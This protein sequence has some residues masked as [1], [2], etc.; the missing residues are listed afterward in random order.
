MAD[1]RMKSQE[2]H[3]N[4]SEPPVDVQPKALQPPTD[5]EAKAA[6][7]RRLFQQLARMGE[8]VTTG[9]TSTGGVITWW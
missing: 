2:T 5:P 4:I 6:E 3:I 8:G 9:G 7:R 1:E